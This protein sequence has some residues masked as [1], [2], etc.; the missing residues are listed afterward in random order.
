[1]EKFAVIFDVDGLIFDAEAVWKKAFKFA[2]KQHGIVE[3]EKF[4]QNL[5][6]RKRNEVVNLLIESHST[7]NAESFYNVMVGKFADYVKKHGIKLKDE[8]F[9]KIVKNLRKKGFK[10]AIAT[11]STRERLD[12]LFEKVDMNP[13]KLF[14]VIVTCDDVTK[15]KPN[16]EIY[17]LTV[18]KLEIPAE[19]CYALEDSPNGIKSAHSAGCKPILVVD[20]IKPN[21]KIEKICYRVFTNLRDA[22]KSISTNKTTKCQ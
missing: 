12:L 11:G 3:T 20:L 2:C 19:N 17:D 9:E 7:L 6:G 18:K 15:G 5:C 8:N 10:T 21:Q 14:D 4:R 16:S 22:I 13:S 1:M